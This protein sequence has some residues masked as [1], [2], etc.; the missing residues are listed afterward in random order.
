M[1]ELFSKYFSFLW[2]KDPLIKDHIINCKQTI[3]AEFCN[4]ETFTEVAFKAKN[5]YK[6]HYLIGSSFSS[7]SLKIFAHGSHFYN[8]KFNTF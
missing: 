1:K 4:N 8:N 2:K 6:D 3:Q 5:A 7:E